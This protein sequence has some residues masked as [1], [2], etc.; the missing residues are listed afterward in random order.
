MHSSAANRVE[1]PVIEQQTMEECDHSY[2]SP[3]Q[4]VAIP[5]VSNGPDQL[6]KR[7]ANAGTVREVADKDTTGKIAVEG[8]LNTLNSSQGEH[9]Q[10]Q[11]LV[12]YDEYRPLPPRLL[13]SH[14]QAAEAG[15]GLPGMG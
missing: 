15:Q 2:S 5:K 7:V 14:S 1:S 3:P 13:H 6:M 4:A 10:R 8:P 12:K 11:R 9:Q